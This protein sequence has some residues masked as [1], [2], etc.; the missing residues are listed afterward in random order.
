MLQRSVSA[1]PWQAA[2]TLVSTA[3]YHQ[4][5]STD[6]FRTVLGTMLHDSRDAVA[7]GRASKAVSWH[8]AVRVMSEAYIAHGNKTPSR[9]PLSTLRL[10][11]PGREWVQALRTLQFAEFNDHL[12][13]PMALDAA[14]CCASSS[15]WHL[16]MN[17]L[18][19]VHAQDSSILLGAITSLLPANPNAA[20]ALLAD[21]SQSRSRTWSHALQII[22]NVVGSLPPEIATSNEFALSYISHLCNSGDYMTT[23]RLEEALGR[24]AWDDALTLL[25]RSSA[26]IS[27]DTMKLP[28]MTGEDEAT[29]SGGSIVTPASTSG[30]LG[31]SVVDEDDSHR[32]RHVT[33]RLLACVIRRLPLS[34]L[35]DVLAQFHRSGQRSVL[36]AHDVVA[37]QLVVAVRES[38]WE[39]GVQL[40]RGMNTSTPDHRERVGENAI[41]ELVDLLIL[42]APPHVLA[43]LTPLLV[44]LGIAFDATRL[45]AVLKSLL[46]D[47]AHGPEGRQTAG[48]PTVQ[49]VA[50]LGWAF[51]LHNETSVP[52][53]AEKLTASSQP[54]VPA[55]DPKLASVL[56][57]LCVAGGSPQSALKVINRVHEHSHV[58]FA[59]ASEMKALL[60]CMLYGRKREAHAIVQNA[61]EKGDA[62]SARSLASLL[63]RWDWDSSAS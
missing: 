23:N 51:Q 48:S 50:A 17:L 36:H 8:A 55:L 38:Q 47:H 16:A 26:F 2:L 1:L 45:C 32:R 44:N 22:G 37:A 25:C 53:L 11:Q 63:M 12:T 14:G 20:Y 31:D 61:A 62:T 13:I 46:E 7:T 58:R 6:T 41:R 43:T 27:Q 29:I 34:A 56:V 57:H 24:I 28:L 54:V 15:T 4:P 10:L 49:W 18:G 42:K 21:D 59:H 19:R 3:H 39:R 30:S 40:L 60:F 33:S 35:D 5:L 52:D 9:V